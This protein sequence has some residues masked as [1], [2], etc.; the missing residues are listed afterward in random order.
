MLPPP[1]DTCLRPLQTVEYVCFCLIRSPKH[2]RLTGA[3]A[4]D[5]DAL[6]HKWSEAPRTVSDK[7]YTDNGTATHKNKNPT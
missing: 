6:V 4:A 1:P 7:A 2:I 5:E 3:Q